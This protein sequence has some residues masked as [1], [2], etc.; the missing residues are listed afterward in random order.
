MTIEQAK[1]RVAREGG[2]EIVKYYDTYHLMAVYSWSEGKVKQMRKA[3]VPTFKDGG[4][5]KYDPKLVDAW[6]KDV[7]FVTV[8]ESL[9]YS[10]N[11]YTRTLIA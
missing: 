5:N 11:N 4:R 9:D 2:I 10:D 3:G 6:L 8:N 1:Q 7:F